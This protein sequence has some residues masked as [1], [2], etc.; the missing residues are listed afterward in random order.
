MGRIDDILG[1]TI[2][3]D[4]NTLIHAVED[5]GALGTTMRRLFN[6]IDGGEFQSITSELSLA[7][8]LVVPIRT[9][10]APIRREYEQL[11]NLSSGLLV[12]PILRS[13]LI[14]AAELRA[15][16]PSLKL[17]DAIHAATALE[18]GCTTFLTND[19]RFESVPELPV[20]LLSKWI[21][22]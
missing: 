20:L 1:P 14:H 9:G 21:M 18:H 16:G 17:P 15:S 19:R 10:S 7:E 12:L 13:I 4:A 11:L 8:V 6:R 3:L 2:Y 22:E 5:M